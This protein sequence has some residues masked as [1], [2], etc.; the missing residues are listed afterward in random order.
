MLCGHMAIIA[1]FSGKRVARTVLFSARTVSGYLAE[2]RVL[3]NG[4]FCEL[5]YAVVRYRVIATI[6]TIAIFH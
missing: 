6:I 4:R 5:D 3:S 2:V 1:L